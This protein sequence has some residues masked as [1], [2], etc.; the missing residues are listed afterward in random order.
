MTNQERL[1]SLVGFSPDS[2]A[3]EGALTDAELNAGD[4]YSALNLVTIK[5]AAIGLLELLLSTPDTGN[6]TGYY[7]K[8]D[9]NAIL[10]RLDYLKSDLGL[11]KG[12]KIEAIRLW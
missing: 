11:L 3:V 5:K 4:T 2:K 8:Y 6:E 9:R 10:K 1:I 7:I 12:S